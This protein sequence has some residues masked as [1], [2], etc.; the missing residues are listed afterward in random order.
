[1]NCIKRQSERFTTVE[2]WSPS[3]HVAYH[4]LRVSRSAAQ[5]SLHSLD[6]SRFGNERRSLLTTG[7]FFAL[8]DDDN[9]YLLENSH[10]P[11]DSTVQ[12]ICKCGH[13]DSFP[14]R[15]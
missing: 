12:C 7:D 2:S 14:R 8:E 9:D 1:M 15:S 5:T 13:E 6:N 11:M 3:P 10:V 4:P